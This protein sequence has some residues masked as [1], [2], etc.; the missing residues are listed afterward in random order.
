MVP[1]YF[2]PRGEKEKKNKYV[3]VFLL[4]WILKENKENYFL[5]NKL[6]RID[7]Y[8]IAIYKLGNYWEPTV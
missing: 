3:L 6:A 8:T 2:L 1:L 5:R 4:L 7:I